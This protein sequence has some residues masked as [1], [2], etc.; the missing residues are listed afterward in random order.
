[1]NNEHFNNALSGFIQD[2][3]GGGA[4]R[5]MADTGLTVREIH[6]RLDYPLSESVVADIVWK[7]FTDTGVIRL[8]VPDSSPVERKSYI[9][10]T[11]SYGRTSFRMIREKTEA[12]DAGYIECS[13]G[14]LKAKDGRAYDEA[15]NRL[16]ARDREYISGLPWPRRK[17]WHVADERMCRIM[18]VLQ[19]QCSSSAGIG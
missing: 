9:R 2:F 10:E 17:V 7:H 3:A 16:E 19:D 8:N 4:V 1:M 15:L 5:H 6:D 13:F 14:I 11:D 18:K 12:P